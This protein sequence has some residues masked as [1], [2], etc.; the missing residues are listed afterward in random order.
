[1]CICC[2]LFLIAEHIREKVVRSDVN[3]ADPVL[4]QCSGQD[5]V[6]RPFPT[7]FFI[8]LVPERQTVNIGV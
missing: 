8:I 7:C 4:Q 1:M 5:K 3:R 2:G 6:S